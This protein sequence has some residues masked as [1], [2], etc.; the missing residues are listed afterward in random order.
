MS[1]NAQGKTL[2]DYADVIKQISG[3]YGFPVV[4]LLREG[5]VL[6]KSTAFMN[7]YSMDGLHWN[8][9]FHKKYI[10]PQLKNAVINHAIAKP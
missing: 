6:H 4:D 1:A 8:E 10:Y 5:N 2:Y 7:E 3:E 9:S